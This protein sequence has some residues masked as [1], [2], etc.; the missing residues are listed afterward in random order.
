MEA[1][2]LPVC[3]E[4][5]PT[6]ALEVGWLDELV[7]QYGDTREAEGFNYSKRAKPAGIFKPK[8]GPVSQ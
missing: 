7:A 4:A 3:V 6:R 5:C 2:K 1:K 8:R